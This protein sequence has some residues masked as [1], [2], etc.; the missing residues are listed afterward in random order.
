M[1]YING[2]QVRDIIF[3]SHSHMVALAYRIFLNTFFA[4]LPPLASAAR[5]G[6][7][8]RTSLATPLRVALLF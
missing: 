3:I 4:R 2:R 1:S 5:C 8:P 6:P 7:H